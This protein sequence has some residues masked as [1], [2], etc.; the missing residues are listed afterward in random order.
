M[1]I[2]RQCRR[3]RFY[4]W[5]GKIP[6]WR[7]WLLTPVFLPGKSNGQRRLVGYSQSSKESD[8]SER[9]T[10]SHFHLPNLGKL[11]KKTQDKNKGRKSDL[12]GS[13]H[14]LRILESHITGCVT[15]LSHPNMILSTEAASRARWGWWGDQQPWA[16]HTLLPP[17]SH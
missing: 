8:T 10:L 9:L 16:R 4:P 15:W 6:W 2:H 13:S 17:T 3:P 11:K 1:R 7:E 12:L 5:D 14:L